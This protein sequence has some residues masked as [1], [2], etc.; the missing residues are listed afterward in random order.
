MKTTKECWKELRAY[1]KKNSN[2][3]PDDSLNDIKDKIIF[4]TVLKKMESLQNDIDPNEDKID[5]NKTYRFKR[6]N[7]PIF[8]VKAFGLPPKPTLRKF[9]VGCAVGG[10]MEHLDIIYENIQIIEAHNKE[11]AKKI[12]DE[13]NDCNYYYGEVL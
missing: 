3:L 11:E 4:L 1:L 7:T 10:V 2:I 6:D 13:I 8:S 9:K 12:Y 5:L